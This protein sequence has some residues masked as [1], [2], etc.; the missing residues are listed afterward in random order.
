MSILIG[1]DIV[2]TNSNFDLF[3]QGDIKNLVGP[4]LIYQLGRA[5]FR[6]FNLEVPLTNDENPIF[7]HGSCLSAPINCING[8]VRLGIN[9]VTIA[10]NHI[11]DQ[12]K[13]GLLSTCNE[14]D[15]KGIK[16]FGAGTDI[17]E[18]SKPLILEDHNKKVGII[19][20]TD[21]EFSIATE[22]TA[23][24]CPYDLY[25]IIKQI[26]K[27]KVSCDYIIVL[28]HGGKEEYPYPTPWLMKNCR[29]LAD[30]G[31]NLIIC[32]HSHCIGCKEEYKQ[33][34]IVYGQGNFLF[35]G[36]ENDFWQTGLLLFINDSFEI[37]YIPIKKAG[38]T[39]RLANEEES[40]AIIEGFLKRSTEIMQPE[41]VR[42]KFQELAERHLEYYLLS[43]TG[44][45]DKFWFRAI[46]KLTLYKFGKMYVKV[47]FNREALLAIKNYVLCEAHRELL[48]E[49]INLRH[50]KE[51]S[52]DGIM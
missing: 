41:F 32:Q 15:K 27:L 49:G 25:Q 28:Y 7:K 16:W 4:D 36:E 51:K 45:Q 6:V 42:Q 31:A 5:D 33:S 38:N 12:G 19:A 40:N 50:E 37:S 52:I 18:A 26:H 17:L 34:T 29:I 35:D 30:E 10:N 43:M 39:V 2:P 1:A 24:A 44:V 46:N 14:L 48:I 20:C 8:Y 13:Q 22:R 11:Y 9:A 47:R 23:G 21:H 3:K